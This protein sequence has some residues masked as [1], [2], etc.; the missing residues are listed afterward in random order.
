MGTKGNGE[1]K[2]KV[3]VRP[4]RTRNRWGT[5]VGGDEGE[6][7]PESPIPIVR[8]NLPVLKSATEGAAVVLSIRD[9]RIEVTLSGRFLGEVSGQ[10]E[11]RLRIRNS[12]SGILAEVHHDPPSATFYPGA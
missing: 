3:P 9:E 5:G 8:L 6:P 10:H 12:T 7:R 4:N 1:S 11:R 2:S